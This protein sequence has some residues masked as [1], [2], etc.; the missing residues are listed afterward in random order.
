MFDSIEGII[1]KQFLDDKL[2]KGII[3]LA[4]IIVLVSLISRFLSG[5]ETLS[6]YAAK[7]PEQQISTEVAK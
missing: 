4:A 2:I 3:A 7:H 5:S 6:E 1:M